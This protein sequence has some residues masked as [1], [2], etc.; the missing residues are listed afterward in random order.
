[1][2]AKLI[3]KCSSYSTYKVAGE[4]DMT[5]WTWNAGVYYTYRNHMFPFRQRPP[6]YP[7]IQALMLAQQLVL[8]PND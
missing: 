6:K 4:Y 8:I 3:D 7:T 2:L 1:M 5:V